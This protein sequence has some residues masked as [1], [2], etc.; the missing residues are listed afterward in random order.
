VKLVVVDR[1]RR[2]GCGEEHAK[3]GVPREF[4]PQAVE[5][6]GD[7]ALVARFGESVGAQV[8]TLT[9]SAC[10]RACSTDKRSIGCTSRSTCETQLSERFISLASSRW[11]NPADAEGQPLAR[12]ESVSSRPRLP[13]S[14]VGVHATTADH[15]LLYGAKGTRWAHTPPAVLHAPPT[16]GLERVER[17]PT[18]SGG[19][20]VRHEP[21]GVPGLPVGC[22]S[23]QTRPLRVTERQVTSERGRE[24]ASLRAL[25]LL[26]H[27]EPRSTE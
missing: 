21:L 9:P 18:A 24:P 8:R 26:I 13:H 25:P 6:V 17:C 3:C 22:F 12:R 5:V 10:A 1:L 14:G 11:E 23:A 19:G 15:E 16:T 4:E 20:E 7:G 2:F 27:I